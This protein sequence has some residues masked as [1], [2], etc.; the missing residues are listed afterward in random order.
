MGEQSKWSLQVLHR[1]FL[2]FVVETSDE[3]KCGRIA[4]SVCVVGVVDPNDSTTSISWASVSL[5]AA[6][7]RMFCK[8]G[9]LSAMNLGDIKCRVVYSC[10]TSCF[11]RLYCGGGR[12]L[13]RGGA[14]VLFCGCLH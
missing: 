4:V 3:R 8:M 14:R 2:H 10:R 5:C 12:D 11:S 7:T 13:Y 6:R 1:E 9:C